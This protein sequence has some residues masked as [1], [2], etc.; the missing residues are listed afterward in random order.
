VLVSTVPSR[1]RGTVCRVMYSLQTQTGPSQPVTPQSSTAR[2]RKVVHT[3][4]QSVIILCHLRRYLL[5]C[6]MT[7]FQERRS[8]TVLASNGESLKKHEI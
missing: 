2:Y 3:D 1:K 6:F 8:H 7:D 4:L 5:V